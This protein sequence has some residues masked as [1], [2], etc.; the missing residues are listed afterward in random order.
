MK[1]AFKRILSLALALLMVVVLLPAG[2]VTSAYALDDIQQTEDYTATV[3]AAAPPSVQPQADVSA[4]AAAT[5]SV[6]NKSYTDLNAAINAAVN[7][8]DKTIVVAADG[9]LSGNYTIPAGVTLLV[10]FDDASTLYTDTPKYDTTY[11]NPSVY[12][13]LVLTSGA[14]LEVNG[15]ISVGS[16][17][18]ANSGNYASAPTG[19][20]GEIA[21]MSGSKITVNNGGK[22][23]AWGYI[24]GAGEITAK[25]GAKTYEYFQIAD[26]RGGSAFM[27]MVNNEKRVFPFSQY[28]VQN[29]Q[30]ALTLEYGATEYTLFGPYMKKWN[31]TVDTPCL[32]EFVG[33][34]GMFSL[35]AGST[36][37]KRYLTGEDRLQVDVNGDAT[38]KNISITLNVF[39][40][41]YTVDSK[42]YTLPINNNITVRIHSGTTKINQ[43]LALL[44]GTRI[45]VDS[46]AGVEVSSGNK[47][48]LYDAA[49][50]KTG[51]YVFQGGQNY[52]VSVRFAPGK[53]KTRTFADLIDAK[54]DVNGMLTA[55]GNVYTTT[56][57][58]DICS[59]SGCGK[60]I[61][62]SEVGGEKV[63]YQALSSTSF[64]EIPITS[65]K[66]HNADGTYT[67]TA[68]SKAGDT[69]VYANGKWA[70]KG[71]EIAITFDSNGGTGTMAAMSVNPGVDN[72]LSANVFIRENYT[73]TGWNTTADGTGTAYA[74]GATVNFN[75]DTTLYAQWT[76]N[77]VITFNANGGDGLMP[78]QTVQPGAAAALTANAFTRA[79]YDFAGWNTAADG[80]GT[81]YAD[82]ADITA[83]E[84]VT[85][86]AQW[87]LHKYHVRWL[88]WDRTVLQEGDYT[89]EQW[90]EWDFAN[91]DPSRPEDENHTYKFARRWTPYDAAEKIDGWGF[92]PHM[93]VDFTA[94]FNSFEKLTVTFDANGGTG[95]MEPVKIANGSSGEGYALPECGF[96]REGYAFDG[97]LITGTVGYTQFDKFQLTE[98]KWDDDTLLAFS[99][100]ILKASWK[101]NTYTV[102]WKND[103]GTVLK[104][105]TVNYGAMPTYGGIPTKSADAQYTYCF[106][107]WT[108]EVA[109]VMGDVTYS[110]VY[111]EQLRSYTVKWVN[112]DGTTL[113][114]D[115]VPYGTVP[116]YGAADP[117]R[118][119]DAKN[120]YAF[121]G[122]DK[123]IT[124]VTGNVTYTAQFTAACRHAATTLRDVKDATCTESG[125]TG[126]TYC[127]D[128][129]EKLS[130]G[131]VIPAKGHTEV[132][133]PAVEPTCTK[134][135]LT[136]GK[137]C[138]VCNEVIVAQ[139]VIPAAGHT[140]VIDPA[141]EPTCTK[142][143]LTEG[144][145][146][147]VCNEVIVAQ[148]V[149]PAAG[150]TEVI[151]GRKDATL[152]ED[153]Y[154]GDT[155][156]S[157]CDKLL[158]TGTV[159]PKTGATV[160]W[161]VDG[162][163]TTQV[164]A[165]GDVP[166]YNG[167]P[168]KA[169]T[170][171]YTYA[172]TGWDK[173]LTAV[174]GDVTYTAQFQAVGKNGLCID[175][176]DTYWLENGQIVK[177]KGL[178]QVK[179][180]Q[181]HN[182][183]YYFG[184]DGKAVKN[185]LPAG[186]H[187]FWISAD[188]T[189]GLLPEWGYYFDENGVI[190]HNEQ[191]QNGI[192]TE[193]DAKYYYI[194]GIRVHMGM[195]QL[196]GSYY[197]AKS[198]GQLVT[199][200]EYYCERMNDTGLKAG[201]YAFDADGKL[202]LKKNGIVA[203][204]GSLY[205]YK[206]GVLNYAGLIEID[207]SYYYVKTSGEVVHGRNYWISKTNGLM[208]ERSYTFADDGKMIDPEIKD[209]KKDGIVA[210]DGSL[211]YYK[212]GLRTYAG[213]I[214]ID[215]SYYYVK[216]SG[217]VVHGRSY[218]ITKTNGLMSER[219][220]T[221]ADDGKMIDPEIKDTTKDGIVAENGS[222]YYYKDGV[223]N[224]AGLIEIDG[225][226]YYVK[227]SGEVVHGRSYWITKTNGLMAE[228]SYT[229]ADD[230]RMVNPG[231]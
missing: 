59:S 124:A 199:G 54:I 154:T 61:Q 168:T 152:T 188:K 175:G 115:T 84:N 161:I 35:N 103:D 138:S 31:F 5:F 114:E 231:K 13:K 167:T 183:Y 150:H 12:R 216:T 163:T 148:Q 65:A 146:C 191:F 57:G 93:D 77:P 126:D 136:E 173:E 132:I 119:A 47:V 46:G 212:D 215:G 220:Y 206:D 3:Q 113:R 108:P 102:T 121:S 203:E 33:A 156:C 23:Y 80:T 87:K 110:A 82:G 224:Y 42:S 222:L 4:D 111:T 174:T 27:D 141:V 131:A 32:I 207:G 72:K 38:L 196:D 26:W 209:T 157:V 198:S 96:T 51:G 129:G 48:Y 28:Y 139:Q 201:K 36:L 225:S 1:Q 94:V 39:G 89:C 101:A 40:L 104:T 76:Q 181:G 11:S 158:E 134:T 147:S 99:N 20:Y 41:K 67:E 145:H 86:Y 123:E 120:T 211:Y 184:A 182:L 83:S 44:P 169:E 22:L 91:D 193:D 228:R 160:T 50:W 144:K 204:N 142:T 107:G 197:Y 90:A 133:D 221:F 178:T 95:T 55:S 155:Y 194:D 7:G 185:V 186:G 10:P 24:T 159:I 219:S 226:Y 6:D 112:W 68:A 170:P 29:I 109:P 171:Y 214:E 34:N 100:L 137:H 25:S 70:V 151:R 200:K 92:Y 162:V 217:E 2:L 74:D 223:L 66:L 62:F 213:L 190:I 165:Y 63:T 88:N 192:V 43:D 118:A 179:D 60:Y 135:G 116:A 210:E 227:T 8:D 208:P 105:E 73:F 45:D 16:K 166:A 117:T 49:A 79:D 71:N 17:Y 149:I 52:L 202:I 195:F 127:A 19:K 98:E 218:W 9:T 75:A 230:G 177:D 140:E 122:W 69:Y 180:A 78:T 18:H 128:C 143:G 81:A 14:T 85:L 172:F 37:T 229:F 164:Y 205:Y 125:Y 189:N 130:G 53:A 97:W 176:D 30:A 187:D 21:M 15:S 153:G 56:N 58:A 64:A 106:T